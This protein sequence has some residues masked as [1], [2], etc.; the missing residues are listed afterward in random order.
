MALLKRTFDA[1][2]GRTREGEPGHAQEVELSRTL[3][4][5]L[6]EL[7]LSPHALVCKHPGNWHLLYRLARAH[8]GIDRPPDFLALVILSTRLAR[9]FGPY[10]RLEDIAAADTP[11][12]YEGTQTLAIL[13]QSAC[14]LALL[15]AQ[16]LLRNQPGTW[17]P[18]DGMLTALR[19]FGGPGQLSAALLPAARHTSTVA[20][21]YDQSAWLA[22][23]FGIP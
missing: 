10:P 15:T 19:R 22:E 17:P 6:G 23:A 7:G 20:L 12:W 14:D 16:R 9:N 4:D 2:P 8:D 18:E 13:I 3:N 21:P 1:R 5:L 11:A